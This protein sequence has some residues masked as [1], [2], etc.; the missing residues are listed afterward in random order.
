MYVT[1]DTTRADPETLRR[2][3]STAIRA[4][5]KRVCVCDTVGHAT[6]VG[7]AAVVTFIAGVVEE[8]GG[9][10]R[11][12]LARPP[13]SR[14]RRSSTRSPR[15]TPARPACTATAIGI[16]ERVGNTPM[17]QLLVNLMLMGYIEHD[18]S[19]L[20][21]YCA[22]VSEATGVPIPPNYP[23]VGRDAFRTGDR[24][25]RR[26]R[27]QGVPQERPRPRRRGVLRR[28]GQSGRPGAGD[29][30][31]ADVRQVERRLLAR[32]ARHRGDRRARASES[33]R[34]RRNPTACSARRRFA[35]SAP[36]ARVSRRNKAW[37]RDAG[38]GMRDPGFTIRDSGLGIRDSSLVTR[39]P[40]AVRRQRQTHARAR[41]PTC[42]TSP[43]SN[44]R[45][46]IVMPCGTRRGGLNFGSGC[47]GSGAQS[48]RASETFTNPARS[49]SDGCPVKFVIVSCSSRSD[50]TISTSTSSEDARHLE[51]DSSAGGDPPARY[52]QPK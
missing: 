12:R 52:R 33:S 34:R 38:S 6:P 44:N 26:R 19:A 15:S 24:R 5:A 16:G 2:L 47:A 18:L 39:T 40:A 7:A 13:R 32:E 41:V 36:A 43:S 9:G 25:A 4:G 51:R 35:R 8:C 42:P 3:Y 28:A 22:L 29:R 11:D 10:S 21:E 48:L 20:V 50:G 37:I 27:D 30:G 14:T 31:R 1:E 49:V 45:P 46:R 23:I 17:D